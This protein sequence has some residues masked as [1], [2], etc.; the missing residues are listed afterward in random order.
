MLRMSSLY[1]KRPFPA[2]LLSSTTPQH[3]LAT[4]GGAHTRHQLRFLCTCLPLSPPC[5]CLFKARCSTRHTAPSAPGKPPN[6]PHT[7]PTSPHSLF[8]T[9]TLAFL[10]SAA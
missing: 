2:P 8:Q 4:V 6:F 7:R 9:P 1:N 10:S 3:M 5:H